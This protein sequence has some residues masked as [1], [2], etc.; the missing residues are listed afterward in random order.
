MQDRFLVFVYGTLK[1]GFPNHDRYM[2]SAERMGTFRTRDRYRL[3]LNGE[4]YSPCLMDGAGQGRCVEGEVFAVDAS[5][6]KKLD[7]LERIDRPD[8]YHR[9][10]IVVDAVDS[11]EPESCEVFVYLKDPE[12]V[13]DPRS[14]ALDVYTLDAARA[15]RK[16]NEGSA[17]D[18]GTF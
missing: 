1:K 6:L 2:P 13:T 10:R 12:W 8:G 11:P 5:G 18:E 14:D 9:R 15:Y 17:H 7:R 4:R 16:R 3:V